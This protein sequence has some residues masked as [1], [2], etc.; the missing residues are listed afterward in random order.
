MELLLRKMVKECILSIKFTFQYGATST[1]K[2]TK[3]K[4]KKNYLHS[5]MELLLQ[6]DLG[7]LQ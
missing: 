5:N 3:Q 2:L 4:L 1:I 7:V 6:N